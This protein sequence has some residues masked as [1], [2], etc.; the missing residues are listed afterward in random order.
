MESEKSRLRKISEQNTSFRD[1]T[2]TLSEQPI[3]S[4][5][6][7]V[8]IFL[9]SLVKHW[10]EKDKMKNAWNPFELNIYIQVIS[11]STEPHLHAIVTS[12]THI[13]NG[14]PNSSLWRLSYDQFMNIFSFVFFFLSLFNASIFFWT[15]SLKTK[16]QDCTEYTH[17]F[18]R[19]HWWRR[20]IIANIHFLRTV[21]IR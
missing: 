19:G 6:N 1:E 13:L 16:Q 3:N 12:Q 5:I 9:I 14:T 2:R 21:Q 20:L 8:L 7:L 11:T 17:R 15:V 10:L 4:Y 18:S